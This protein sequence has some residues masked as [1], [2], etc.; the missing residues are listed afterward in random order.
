VGLAV[1]G[2]SAALW[3]VSWTAL[4][5]LIALGSLWE[6]DQLGV[7]KGTELE[8]AVA[9]PAV[10][11]YVVLTALGL[12]HRYEGVLLAATVTGAMAYAAFFQK[13]SIFSRAGFT[14]LAVLYIGKLI[15]YFVVIRNVPV[16][17]TWLVVYAIVVIAFTDM[18]AMFVGTTLGRTPL[19]ELSPKKTVEGA[20]G[21]FVAAVAI[22]I[23][24]GVFPHVAIGWWQGALVGAITSIAA[25]C[26]DLVESALKRDANVKDAGTAI[27]S[28]GGVLDRFDSYL[29]GGPAFYFALYVVH[30]VHNGKLF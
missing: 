4:V 5:A 22:G 11:A 8:L 7:R 10:L 29:F 28:H 27:G 21:G 2:F 30:V 24:F 20:L 19:T 14:V 18:F 12:I 3:P 16:L 1:V 17:G 6:F 23:A 26:G 15:S 9:A 25:Q 13:G